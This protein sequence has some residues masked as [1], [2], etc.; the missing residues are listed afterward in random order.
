VS[1]PGW[2]FWRVYEYTLSNLIIA[3][4]IEDV[5]RSAAEQ[6]FHISDEEKENLDRAVLWFFPDCQANAV[7]LLSVSL[8]NRNILRSVPDC[9][10]NT[11]VEIDPSI[12]DEGENTLS[13]TI[14]QGS[15]LFD[16]VKVKTELEELLYPVYY[17]DIDE[18]YFDPSIDYSPDEE[19]CGNIDGVCP[20]NCDEDAD[21]DCCFEDNPDN[22][23]CDIETDHID[24]RC[25]GFVD[26]STLGRCDSGYEEENG[27]IVEI[28]EDLCGDDDDDYCPSGCSI[29]YDKDCCFEQDPNN[30]WCDDL[31][32][33]GVSSICEA[34][35]SSGECDDCP[36]GYYSDERGSPSCGVVYDEDD[37]E[38]VLRKQYDIN[39]TLRFVNEREDHKADIIVNGRTIHMDTNK[40][41]FSKFI[42]DYVESG[43]NSLEIIPRTTLDIV[44][45]TVAIEKHK[46]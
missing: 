3:A 15:V 1:S 19:Y 13:F 8:N 12:L 6:R 34:D 39:L 24:D 30:Y 33:T 42:D 14:S 10:V 41:F 20:F 31:P 36:T 43:V 21:K 7:G 44:R 28:G 32:K 5:S 35:I 11:H 37:E 18:D 45:L 27:N 4:D 17:F 23:W 16:Q 26:S 40:M 29:Y 25:V 38:N 22:Y 2:V 9:G 46:R